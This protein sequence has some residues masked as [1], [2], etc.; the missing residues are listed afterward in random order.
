MNIFKLKSSTISF[1]VNG[2]PFE[3]TVFHTLPDVFSLSMSDA[4]NSWVHRTNDYSEQSLCDYI[5]SKNTEGKAYTSKQL[6]DKRLFFE[7]EI[8]VKEHKLANGII[9]NTR[10]VRVANKSIKTWKRYVERINQ[11]L[12]SG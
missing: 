2:V 8:K 7:C 12:A 11:L 10:T 9:T 1:E 4:V 5:N 6:R 3:F